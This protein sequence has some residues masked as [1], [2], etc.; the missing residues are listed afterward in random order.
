MKE[1]QSL[2]SLDGLDLV[3][4]VPKE[5]FTF[6]ADDKPM[7]MKKPIKK[8]G[9]AVGST[10]GSVPNVILRK[11]SMFNEYNVGEKP[12]RLRIKPNLSLKMGNGQVVARGAAV[13][14]CVRERG[15]EWL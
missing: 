14:G 9:N 12:S 7:E 13:N 4:P 5:G 15:G 2:S 1:V 3:R 8:V 11:R 10:K 6:E